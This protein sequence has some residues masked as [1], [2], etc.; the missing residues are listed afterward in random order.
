MTDEAQTTEDSPNFAQLRDANKALK[1]ENLKL[2]QTAAKNMIDAA[3]YD[4]TNKMTDLVLDQYLKQDSVDLS[5]TA[6]RDFASGYGLTPTIGDGPVDAAPDHSGAIAELQTGGDAIRSQSVQSQPSPT[7]AQKIAQ[8]EQ[9]G[10]WSASLGLKID[11]FRQAILD[12]R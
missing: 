3:G 6:F 5:A 8:A 2:R 12:N 11:S 10:D 1:E 7:T 9:E 4:T